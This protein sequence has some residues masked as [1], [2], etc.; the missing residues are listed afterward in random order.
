MISAPLVTLEGSGH[1][2]IARD[3][4]RMNLLI[5]D[6]ADRSLGRIA[7]PAVFRHGLGRRNRVLYRGVEGDGSN[8]AAQLLAELF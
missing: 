3:P 4:V 8:R 7:A 5:R 2:P 1:V 6:F